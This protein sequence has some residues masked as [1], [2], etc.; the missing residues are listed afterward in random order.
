M[1]LEPRRVEV[2][3]SPEGGGVGVKEEDRPEARMLKEKG[4]VV[5]GEAAVVVVIKER[6]KEWE[7]SI[8]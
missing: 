5:W 3:N 4:L 1:V 7:F 8:V 6:G 2:F